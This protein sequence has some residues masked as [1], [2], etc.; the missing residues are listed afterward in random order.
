MVARTGPVAGVVLAPL[1]MLVAA[2]LPFWAGGLLSGVSGYPLRPGVLLAGT[3]GVAALVLAAFA[4]RESFAPRA[5]RYPAWRLDLFRGPRGLAYACLGT[6]ALLGLLLQFYY[7]TGD[8]TIPLGALGI[9]GG[10]FSF[11]QPLC[12]HRRGLGEI[13]GAL[14]F[15]LLPVATGFYLQCGHLVTEVLLYGLP[16][17]WA[18]FNLFLGY[19][20][21]ENIENKDPKNQKAPQGEAAAARG[22]AVRLGPAP[23]ALLYTFGN[24]LV[25]LGLLAIFFF[26]ASPLPWRAGLWPLLLLAAVNQE[27]IKRRAYRVETR[28]R[29]LCRLSLALHL[30]M[31]AVFNLMLWQRL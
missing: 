30:G 23:A 16:L 31:G 18:G 25:I 11:A 29:W 7:R 4:G 19:G 14:C 22:L 17:T 6:A 12:W 10:Y 8:L 15:G 5:G 9:L 3:L 24:L 1:P 28:L 27:M 20:F 13:A 2:C 21:P 26:P